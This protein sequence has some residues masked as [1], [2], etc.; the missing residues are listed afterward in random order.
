MSRVSRVGVD[1]RLKPLLPLSALT[2]MAKLKPP[3]KWPM[4]AVAPAVVDNR[5]PRA[6]LSP[7]AAAPAI[8]AMFTPLLPKLT[9]PA[10]NFSSANSH[11]TPSSWALLSDT[12]AMI[13][14]TTTW[15][16]RMS[17]CS[18]MAR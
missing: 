13:A 18:T 5:S 4:P 10:P 15:A 1:S 11:C 16:R 14:S 3:P 2:S 6:W 17:S 7:L 8:L 12:S 9:M